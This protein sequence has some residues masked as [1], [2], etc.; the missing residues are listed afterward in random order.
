MS[1][2]SANSS[3]LGLVAVCSAA[4]VGC[5][6]E[7]R[8]PTLAEPHAIVKLRR[9]YDTSG[10]SSLNEQLLVDEHY[11]YR[12][13]VPSQLAATPRIDSI[14]VYPTPA[15][16]EMSNRFF[17]VEMRQEYE[18]YTV[19]TP[20]TSTESYSCGSGT[21]Y[22]TCTRTVT[23]YHSETRYRWVTRP[24]EVSDGA[25]N[26]E[27]RFVPSANRVYLLQY[28]YQEPNVCSLACFE[29]VPAAEGTFQNQPCVAAP[30][31]K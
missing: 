25:C 28:N 12:S 13:G 16:F 26:S 17:H 29:Q 2:M 11:A 21:S 7:Y 4:L 27:L 3:W 8:P 15:T 9:S 23:N 31:A 10:G 5:I 20:Y 30:E 14:L 18:S 24:V 6:P 22:Q 19:Q 1:G